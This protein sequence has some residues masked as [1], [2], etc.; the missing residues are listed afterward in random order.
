[1]EFYPMIAAALD[2]MAEESTTINE[3]GRI[4]NVYSDSSRVKG[5]LEDLFF[6]RLDIHTSLPMWTR[7]TVK[8][9]DNFAFLN[10]NDK[11]GITGAKQMPNYEM[12]RH[13]IGLF[14]MINNTGNLDSETAKSDKVKFY[15]RGR[16][17]EF[18]SWQM[19]HFRLLG[20]DRRLPYGT[21]V[22]EKARR[23][24]KQLIL[25][26]DSM[27]VYRVSRAPERRVY[28]IY[29]GKE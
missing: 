14:E 23:T 3:R 10:I 12:E 11:Y 22:L 28:K 2:I 21:S 20:D 26:E 17:I 7:N 6:N 29:V 4:L 5:V 1:M 15:W 13:E 8:Y 9:G 24:W 25:S 16:D 18:N 27:L 19:A